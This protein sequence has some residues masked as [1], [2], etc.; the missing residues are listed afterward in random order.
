LHGQEGEIQR[1]AVCLDAISG[2]IYP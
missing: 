2:L 1:R